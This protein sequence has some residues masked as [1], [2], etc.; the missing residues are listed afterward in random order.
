MI[1]VST[2]T[3]LNAPAETVWALISDFGSLSEYVEA[4]TTCV[5]E[6]EGIGAVRVITL[7]DGA[8]LKE[9]LERLE[10]DT[11]T[12]EYSITEGPLPVA[13]YRSV[14]TLTET[15]GG[16]TLSWE[17]RFLADGASDEEAAAAMKGIYEMGF[18]GLAR[19][20]G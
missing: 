2:K 9:R 20:F 18:S 19:I 13:D 4:A 14:M 10:A 1:N 7:P 16:C 6:G 5:L 15:E 3:T 17:G 12:L 11:M 8:I